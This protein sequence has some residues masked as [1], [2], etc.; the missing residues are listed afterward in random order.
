MSKSKEN[1]RDS[2]TEDVVSWVSEYESRKMVG[3]GRTIE[4]DP[5]EM[6][7]VVVA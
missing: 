2:L 5:R 7:M 6:F 4:G 1:A 3:N